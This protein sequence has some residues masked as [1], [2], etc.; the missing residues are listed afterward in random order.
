MSV[1]HV[2]IGTDNGLLSIPGQAIIWTNARLLSIGTM[3]L[4]FS[5][6]LIKI[7]TLSF[8]KCIWKYLQNFVQGKM[9]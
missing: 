8:K 1:N 9:S 5:E 3:G 7:N 2:S 4:N 6:I